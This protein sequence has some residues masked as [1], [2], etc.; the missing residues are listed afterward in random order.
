M[1][2][3]ISLEGIIK[4]EADLTQAI[5]QIQAVCVKENLVFEW[6]E[7]QGFIYVCPCGL[8][9]VTYENHYLVCKSNAALVGPGYYVYLVNLLKQMNGAVYLSLDEDLNYEENPDFENVRYAFDNY[10]LN[11]IDVM[12]NLKDE[13]EATYAWDDKSFVPL[14]K[15]GHIITPF[16]YVQN[17]ELRGISIEKARAR[18]YIWNEIEKDA[19]FYLNCALVNLW[20]E[21][22]FENSKQ[23]EKDQSIAQGICEALEKAH[24]MDANLALP[25]DEYQ[26]LCKVLNRPISIKG[27]S[28][29]DEKM[30][31]YRKEKIWFIYGAWCILESGY[32]ISK[33][34][35]NTLTLKL[36]DH[37]MQITGYKSDTVIDDYAHRYLNTANAVDTFEFEGEQIRVKGVVHEMQDEE[38]SL[39][40]QA[41]CLCGK[42]TLLIN[43]ECED[44]EV[45]AQ[46]QNTLNYIYYIQ[47]ERSEKDV[48]I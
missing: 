24:Q 12:S 37:T 28:Q 18:F 11:M 31:G 41:Q 13:D 21:C 25:V 32:A 3:S 15:E 10:L 26:V 6:N 42:E 16:G 14:A 17:T 5:N 4:T 19:Q 34:T 46:V 39:Y 8:V 20:S 40:V 33:L 23:S 35:G 27:V 48:R 22:S 44:M 7:T 30:I 1:A 45:V 43:C 9:E 38:N 2:I 36:K 47:N 29:M